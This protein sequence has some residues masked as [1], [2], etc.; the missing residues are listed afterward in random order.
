MHVGLVDRLFCYLKMI[1][2][3]LVEISDTPAFMDQIF[4]CVLEQIDQFN[5]CEEN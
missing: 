3:F 5:F 4:R 1:A 2:L